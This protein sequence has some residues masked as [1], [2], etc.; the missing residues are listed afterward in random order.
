[1]AAIAVGVAAAAFATYLNGSAGSFSW[2]A[3]AAIFVVALSWLAASA[4]LGATGSTRSGRIALWSLAAAA[5]ALI[6]A[7]A[8][9]R[10]A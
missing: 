1:M 10:G 6:V 4:A 7:V 9:E 8:L 3:E 2:K 5:A